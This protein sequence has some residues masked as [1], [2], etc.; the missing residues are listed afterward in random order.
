MDYVKRK[1][2]AEE[3]RA[4]TQ[5]LMPYYEFNTDGGSHLT[6]VT[7][8]SINGNWGQFVANP[9]FLGDKKSYNTMLYNYYS[10]LNMVR[11][12]VKL[13]KVY[14]K[15]GETIFTKDIGAFYLDG[16]CFSGG[17]EPEYLY[18]YAAYPSSDFY[19]TEIDSLREETR[20]IYRTSKTVEHDYIVLVDDY[21]KLKSYSEYIG[22]NPPRKYAPGFTGDE[23]T[24]WAEYCQ[25]IDDYIGRLNIPASIY[26]KHI[27]V[28]KTMAYVDVEEYLNWLNENKILK[29]KDCCIAKLWEDRGGDDM[30]EFLESKRNRYR[31]LLA[32]VNSL[33]YG[34]PPYI[35]MS[36]SLRQNYTD[37]GV[38]TNVDG[39]PYIEGEKRPH[40]ED[41]KQQGPCQEFISM[42][43][44]IDR[45]SKPQV[46]SLLMTLRNKR[47]FLDDHNNLL[48]GDFVSFGSPEGLM[49]KCIKE[50]NETYYELVAE[51]MEGSD[52][53]CLRYQS[54]TTEFPTYGVVETV[55]EYYMT[56]LTQEDAEQTLAEEI[57]K[58][59]AGDETNAYRLKTAE[60]IWRIYPEGNY[61]EMENCDGEESIK[62]KGTPYG[63][64]KKYRTITIPAAGIRIAVTEEEESGVLDPIGTFYWFMVKY[65]NGASSSKRMKLPF[66]DSPAN[67]TNAYCVKKNDDGKCT[68]YCGD[69]I[70]RITKT[71]NS[72][73]FRYV[74]GGYFTL[75]SQKRLFSS[76]K[77]GG[78]DIY[79]ETYSYSP[80]HL[81][82]YDL[83]G[84]QN[85]PVYSEY[86]D[87]QGAA[88]EFYS[89]RLN[90][91]R[92]G[93]TATIVEVNKTGAVWT[94][95]FS[96]DAYLTKED[97]LINFSSPPEVDVNVTIDRGGVSAFER[98]YKLCECN[99][100]QDLEN[101]ANGWFFEE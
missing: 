91:T 15:N 79:E 64:M 101:Y 82:Y 43:Q 78:G 49:H 14:T 88:K 50:G 83:D 8:D 76:G 65:D 40:G 41:I 92:T 55:P 36:L 58:Y 85:V 62:V 45:N 10:M 34:E 68:K 37:I 35:E 20:E 13:R 86:I 61:I 75:D 89:P 46:E 21:D 48:P 25:I 74:I 44:K 7:E 69:Y 19:S 3:A 38:L 98:H 100:M 24:K 57:A 1:I 95:G 52:M 70:D 80:T 22:S 31:E 32:W 12:G 90:L 39:V 29:E 77:L 66:D 18:T 51:Q 73:T 97:Y 26:N 59:N 2:C 99:T 17:E 47:K 67:Y 72:I 42:T 16:Q 23:H 9:S 71:S 63:N 6:Y 87:F 5:G 27:K 28:P 60:P 56:D 81:G 54:G 33:G 94:S 30:I 11:S 53:W 4:R 96:Y 84:V 93:N